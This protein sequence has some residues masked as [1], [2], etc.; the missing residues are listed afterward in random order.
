MA[1][2]VA[3]VCSGSEI[4]GQVLKD[5]PPL[6]SRQLVGLFVEASS[7]WGKI[8]PQ[9]GSWMEEF[10]LAGKKNS[11]LSL[12]LSLSVRGA[13]RTKPF[14]MAISRP[15]YSYI[16]AD[17]VQPPGRL[18]GAGRDTSPFPHVSA[19]YAGLTTAASSSAAVSFSLESSDAVSSTASTPTAATTPCFAVAVSTSV[20]VKYIFQH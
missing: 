1:H 10:R 16:S 4:F 3:L 9:G 18:S 15:R 2:M 6:V 19:S 5:V 17:T 8:I 20:V 14:F 13:P 12:S 7:F 11:S